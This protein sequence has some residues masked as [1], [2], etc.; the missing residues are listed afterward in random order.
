MEEKSGKL[1]RMETNSEAGKGPEGALVPWMDG[2]TVSFV[3]SVRL[4]VRM[5]QIDS[6]WTDFYEI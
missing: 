1:G 5:E 4:S 3:L 2:W 6:Y